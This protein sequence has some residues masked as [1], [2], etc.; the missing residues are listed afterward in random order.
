MKLTSKL[1]ENKGRYALHQET[2]LDIRP[3][4]FVEYTSP[5]LYKKLKIKFDIYYSPEYPNEAGFDSFVIYDQILYL[6]QF[7]VKLLHDIK[8]FLKFFD[9]CIAIPSRKN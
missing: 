2:V 5:K 1:L 4:A 8:C 3:G 7:T 9:N 6:F